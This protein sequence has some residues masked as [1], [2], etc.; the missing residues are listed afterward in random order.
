MNKYILIQIIQNC[1][2]EEDIWLFFCKITIDVL[3]DT[4][5]KN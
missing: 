2:N 1:N 3:I 5:V 4:R